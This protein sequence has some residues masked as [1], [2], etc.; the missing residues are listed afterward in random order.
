M[1]ATWYFAW[2]SIFRISNHASTLM[3]PQAVFLFG[4]ACVLNVQMNSIIRYACIRWRQHVFTPL[5]SF[6]RLYITRQTKADMNDH[7][8]N[9]KLSLLLQNKP[10]QAVEMMLMYI[11]RHSWSMLQHFVIYA[12]DFIK[13]ATFL[14]KLWFIKAPRAS[15]PSLKSH[16]GARPLF[17]CFTRQSGGGSRW[18]RLTG[19]FR[20]ITSASPPLRTPQVKSLP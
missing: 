7:L 10:V 15:T 4:C 8:G 14:P 11:Y 19:M 1:L 16:V 5:K 6:K 20:K 12:V 3:T 2:I 9:D 18:E 13:T 17:L